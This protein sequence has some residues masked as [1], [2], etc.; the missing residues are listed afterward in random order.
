MKF[1][2]LIPLAFF[3]SLSACSVLPS[4]IE[5]PTLH[6][7]DVRL[8]DASLFE[9]RFLLSLRVQNPNDFK[10]PIEALNYVLTIND[11]PFAQGASAK[12]VTIPRFGSGVI[13]VEGVSTLG[14]LLRQLPELQ[15]GTLKGLRY[16]LKG[17]LTLGGFGNRVPFDQQGEIG[18]S[19][20]LPGSTA[21]DQPR[22]GVF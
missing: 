17:N 19:K 3:V 6:V 20:F 15:G 14:S 22:S 21:P 8:L 2:R 16:Q 13:E 1:F 10:L 5:K 18:I 9:Q 12:A 11:K 4:H 7:A